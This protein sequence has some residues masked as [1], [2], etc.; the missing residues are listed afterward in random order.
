MN[1]PG[2]HQNWQDPTH[3]RA[4]AGVDRAG[5]MWEWLRRDPAY[6]D[7]YEKASQTTC[8][9]PPPGSGS[10]SFW[11][12]NFAESPDISAQQARIIWDAAF[13][14]ATLAITV[15]PAQTAG[16][17]L[18]DLDELTP[19][20]T[21]ADGHDGRQHAVLSDG[22]NRIRL[23]VIEGSLTASGRALIEYK[24][25]G[26]VT[27]QARIVP[28]RR[29]LHLAR[30]RRFSRSLFPKDPRTSRWIALLRV[31]DAMH[32][33]ATQRD[34]GN[35]LFGAGRVARDWNGQSDSLRSRVRRMVGDAR[36]LAQ[37]GYRHLLR[38][39]R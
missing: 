22:L 15:R 33:G 25:S 35:M 32:A 29:F 30:H 26:I 38:R 11:G 31:H 1:G 28:L 27:A 3:Y 37:G 6:I 8:G 10:P 20:L 9:S 24:I 5:I 19:W 18:V 39:S 2:G 13:D 7:W 23:D 34:I 4:L 12:L 16:P 36:S 17:D 14:P 21:V